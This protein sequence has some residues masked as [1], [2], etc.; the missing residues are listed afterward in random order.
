[1]VLKRCAC[2]RETKPYHAQR[3]TNT[4]I[5]ARET[6]RKRER[7]RQRK[8]DAERGRERHREAARETEKGNEQQPPLKF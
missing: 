4:Y 3:G 2:K 8:R 5:P 1:M 6:A 7:E